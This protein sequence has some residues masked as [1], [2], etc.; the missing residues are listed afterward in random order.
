MVISI[1]EDPFSSSFVEI[2]VPVFF[3]ERG[4]ISTIPNCAASTKVHRAMGS[5]KRTKK[6]LG[7]SQYLVK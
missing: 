3:E 4:G 6:Q 7:C 5:K 1:G 2:L